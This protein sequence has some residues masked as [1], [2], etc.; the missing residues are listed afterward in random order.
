MDNRANGIQ[1]P[2]FPRL[3]DDYISPA[4]EEEPGCS[5]RCASTIHLNVRVTLDFLELFT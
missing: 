3:A 2:A 4:V 1:S 5:R